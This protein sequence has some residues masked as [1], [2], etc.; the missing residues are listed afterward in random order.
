MTAAQVT[1]VL[2]VWG[3]LGGD[4]AEALFEGLLRSPVPHLTLEI[5]GKLTDD[6][7]N[8][9][10][11]WV[12]ERNTQS[13]LTMNTWEQLTKEEKDLFEEL[14]LDK[15]PAVTHNVRDVPATPEESR[16]NEFVSIHDLESLIALF[17]E[18]K[19]TGKQYLSATINIKRDND[20]EECSGWLL[21]VLQRKETLKNSYLGNGVDAGGASNTS[22]IA[23][24][25]QNINCTNFS[26][27]PEDGLDYVLASN[28]TLN[29]LSLTFDDDDNMSY[30][31]GLV[32]NTSLKN[33]TDTIIV[34]KSWSRKH[35]KMWHS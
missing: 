33:L 12:E 25:P 28:T 16:D 6:I 2:N 26:R 31:A 35:G 14:Q 22:F 34:H 32:L 3:E 24:T 20:A 11:R 8:S 23:L 19:N 15:N 7:L 9:T 10:A 29:A 17:K 18:A 1:T 21:D 4:G 5:H 13:S 27:E 30:S